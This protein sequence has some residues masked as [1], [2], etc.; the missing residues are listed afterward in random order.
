MGNLSEYIAASR[1]DDI[2][3][4]SGEHLR[5]WTGTDTEHN[6]LRTEDATYT[7]GTGTMQ[8][9]FADTTN[10]LTMIFA[11]GETAYVRDDTNNFEGIV[12]AVTANS[13]TLDFTAATTL[14]V[15]TGDFQIDKYDPT[16]IYNVV[17]T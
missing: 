9:I 3:N 4:P 1:V 15:T 13:I 17:T 6:A 5:F 10:D 12:N 7:S 16:T 14:S 11:V 8:L 2:N